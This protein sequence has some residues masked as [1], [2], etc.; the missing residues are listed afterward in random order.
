MQI[1]N[2]LSDLSNIPL[3]SFVLVVKIAD[4]TI[5]KGLNV[6][7]YEKYAEFYP[8]NSVWVKAFE[9]IQFI[10]VSFLTNQL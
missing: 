1:F 3:Y 10:D 6:V 5:S 9:A 2:R 4:F 7:E 8:E